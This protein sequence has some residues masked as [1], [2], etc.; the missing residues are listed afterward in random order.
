M[1]FF[2]LLQG[3]D[4]MHLIY[5]TVTLDRMKHGVALSDLDVLALFAPQAH[6]DPVGGLAKW[7]VQ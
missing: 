7:Y 6:F 2:F 4:L 3:H 5:F 1:I